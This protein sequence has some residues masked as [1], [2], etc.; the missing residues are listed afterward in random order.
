MKRELPIKD[1]VMS[2]MMAA[3]ILL[4][5]LAFRIPTPAVGYIHVGDAFVLLSGI[6]LG[7]LLGS[8]AAGIGAGLADLLGGYAIWAPGSLIIKALAALAASAIYRKTKNSSRIKN[9]AACVILSGI[10]VALI[11]VAGYFIYHSLVI[12]LIAGGFSKAA[13]FSALSMSAAEIPFNIVQG[14]AGVILGT[15]LAPVFTKIGATTRPIPHT[16]GK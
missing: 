16:S 5:T 4:G 13:F 8:L 12:G 14:I 2:A 6:V 3:L 15:A 1:L 11:V 10:G 9:S 7:P